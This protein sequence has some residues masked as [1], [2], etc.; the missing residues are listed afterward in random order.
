MNHEDDP[1]DFHRGLRTYRYIDKTQLKE[2][3][4]DQHQRGEISQVGHVHEWRTID[5]VQATRRP[6]SIWVGDHQRIPAVVCFFL[7]FYASLMS[8][9]NGCGFQGDR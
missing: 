2:L 1:A 5:R 6:V 7:H 8:A 3:Q 4:Q 9:E